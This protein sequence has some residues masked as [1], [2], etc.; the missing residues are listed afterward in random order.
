MLQGTDS[1]S[2]CSSHNHPPPITHTPKSTTTRYDYFSSAPP[3][4]YIP[5]PQL[6]LPAVIFHAVV[7]PV[8]HAAH[9]PVRCIKEANVC[10]VQSVISIYLFSLLVIYWV[11][12]FLA[13]QK[14]Q[15]QLQP[16][17]LTNMTAVYALASK[18][19][20]SPGKTK[21]YI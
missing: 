8:R 13:L 5:G 19:F 7:L 15:E 18:A 21:L 17:I 4:H 6:P 16:C 3:H 9:M 10:T 14:K 11:F 2:F 12:F 1:S 20:Y